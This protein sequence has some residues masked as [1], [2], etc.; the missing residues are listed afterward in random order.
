M[1]TDTFAKDAGKVEL[2]DIEKKE[3]ICSII[4]FNEELLTSILVNK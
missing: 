1:S 2:W 3:S 4:S